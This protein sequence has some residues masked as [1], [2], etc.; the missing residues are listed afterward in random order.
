MSAWL[1]D[2]RIQPI[3]QDCTD[4]NNALMNKVMQDKVLFIISFLSR[5]A[6]YIL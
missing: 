2:P 6:M 1:Y 5:L 4:W 3:L